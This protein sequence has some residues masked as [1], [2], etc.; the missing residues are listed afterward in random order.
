MSP[1][2]RYC[3]I[4][5]AWNLGWE[6]SCWMIA[7]K[8][9]IGTDFVK[10]SLKGQWGGFSGVFAQIGSSWVS[11]TTFRAIPILASDSRRYSYSK[12]DSPLSPIRGVADSPYRWVGESTTSCITDMQS[13]RL[14]ASTIRRVGNWIFFKENSLYHRYRESWT[15]RTSWVGES[16]T[17]HI[18]DTESRRL[19]ISLSPGVYDSAYRRHGGHYSKKKISLASIF[20]TLNG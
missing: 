4:I 13:R 7:L 9:S 8:T 5:T 18:T 16:P 15:P 11:Y 12:N 14:P 20:S 17:P 1:W 3:R 10:C 2:N 19:R 6:V